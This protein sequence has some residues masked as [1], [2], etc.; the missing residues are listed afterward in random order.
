MNVLTLIPL[1]SM[2]PRLL[3]LVESARDQLMF[4]PIEAASVRDNSV[5]VV[6]REN[7]QP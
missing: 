7:S 6:D 3:G 5:Q 4:A 2:T 1:G